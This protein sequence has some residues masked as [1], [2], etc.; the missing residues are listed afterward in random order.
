MVW[1]GY[2]GL[3]TVSS[4][5]VT[6]CDPVPGLVQATVGHRKQ[7][8]VRLRDFTYGPFRGLILTAQVASRWD[9]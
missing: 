2:Y 1:V 6:F 8:H 7:P 3:A 5:H 4:H 9:P